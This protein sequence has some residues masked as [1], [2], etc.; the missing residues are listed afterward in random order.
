MDN[1]ISIDEHRPH[2]V[3]VDFN[4]NITIIPRVFFNDYVEGKTTTDEIGDDLLR[5][6]VKEWLEAV[7]KN[8][9]I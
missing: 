2:L 9:I 6:I 5:V 7:E 8:E 1:V 3:I 4:S